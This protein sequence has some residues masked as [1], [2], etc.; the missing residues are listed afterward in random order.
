MTGMTAMSDDAQVRDLMARI[1]ELAPAREHRLSRD[2][3]DGRRQLTVP[4]ALSVI[5][6]LE[7]CPVIDSTEAATAAPSDMTGVPPRL[8]DFAG[9]IPAGFYA[10]PSR[11]GNNDLDFWRVNVPANGKWAGYSF[12][13][14]VLGGGTWDQ[15]RTEK[16]PNMQQR[17]ALLAIRE[18]G[19][20]AAAQAFI[21][22]THCCRDCGKMLTDETSRAA[23]RGKVC[24][25]RKG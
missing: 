20:E 17:L 24:R 10:T 13:S 6:H 15:I 8:A 21:D 1:A 12:A 25:S 3:V 14:R 7:G 11:T 4:A 18:A 23:G 5:R 16:L 19:I 9:L 2:M 22:E